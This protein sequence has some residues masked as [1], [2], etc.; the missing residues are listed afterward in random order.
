MYL[1][2]LRSKLLLSTRYVDTPTLVISSEAEFLSIFAPTAAHLQKSARARACPAGALAL[3]DP[4]P[5]RLALLDGSGSIINQ[6][7]AT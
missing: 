6:A 4:A 5:A 3:R 1:V 7:R 2:L